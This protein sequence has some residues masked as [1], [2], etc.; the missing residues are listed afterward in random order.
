MKEA[1]DSFINRIINDPI[2][3]TNSKYVRI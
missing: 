3:G 2:I 1:C